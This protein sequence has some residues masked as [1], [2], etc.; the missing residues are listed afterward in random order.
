MRLDE[1]LTHIN[2]CVANISQSFQLINKFNVLYKMQPPFKI[3]SKE[4]RR[5]GRKG[6]YFGPMK[7]TNK[8]LKLG[9]VEHS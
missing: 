6:K 4:L 2:K 3:F 1:R 8:T 9:V 7:S 5:V